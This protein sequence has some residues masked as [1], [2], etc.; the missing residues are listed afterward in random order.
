MRRFNISIFIMAALPIFIVFAIA[1]TLRQ[2]YRTQDI[3]FSKNPD[4]KS[5]LN[6]SIALE[7]YNVDYDTYPAPDLDTQG[8][9]IVPHSLTT[10]I[11]YMPK[12][13]L[14]MNDPGKPIPYLY[15]QTFSD[16][17]AKHSRGYVISGTNVELFGGSVTEILTIGTSTVTHFN[18]HHYQ[19]WYLAEPPRK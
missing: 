13:P 9:H 14:N 10:P 6:I 2:E 8:R 19:K 3:D 12:L 4:L 15:D 16:I 5:I 1:G 7:G 11:A 18:Y 17:P